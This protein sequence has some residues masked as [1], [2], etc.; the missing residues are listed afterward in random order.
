MTELIDPPPFVFRDRTV[1]GEALA[2]ALR[3]IEIEQDVVVLGLARGGVA[4]ARPVADALGT[5]LDV[6]VAG[7]LGVPGI[8]EVSLGAIAEGTDGVVTDSIAW[9][10]GVPSG[11]VAQLSA[12]GREEVA[13]RVRL[14]RHARPLPDVQGRTVILVDDGISTGATL[15][16]AA[17]A[18]R[19]RHPRRIIAAVPVAS[20]AGAS[21]VRAE[22]DALVVL[23]TTESQQTVS[24]LYEGFSA[25]TDAEVLALLGRAA[26]APPSP[27]L[28]DVSDRIAP[29]IPFGPGE[30]AWPERQQTIPVD[31]GS[32]VADFGTRRPDRRRGYLDVTD[33]TPGLAIIVHG[34]GS[35]RNSYRNRYL[36]GRL[37]MNG[38][39]TLRLDL[40][41]PDEQERDADD[42]SL[43]FDAWRL[44]RRLVATCEWARRRGLPGSENTILIGASTGAAAALCAAAFLRER[45]GA[46]IARGARVDLA[47]DALGEVLAPVMMIVGDTDREVLQ[48]N[49]DAIRR[50]PRGA[51][52]VRIPGA[53]HTFEEPGALGA[54]AE[55]T[56]AWLA[57]LRQSRTRGARRAMR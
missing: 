16:A 13:R 54:A 45:I 52:L 37:R 26:I 19:A 49:R 9:Y 32:L 40:L 42:Q 21:A 38:Y 8:E 18:I 30:R 15:R 11:V 31:G 7:K 1:A 20:S 3:A 56:V 34:G 10:I 50:L 24:A 17:R 35:S 27:I 57:E 5:H 47:S 28:S 53:G 44:A 46:V 12:R 51:Q 22:V 36:A 41:T 6:F 14:Y 25:V 29:A 4:V 43:R 55:R 33:T 2:E 39:S 23:A 48:R